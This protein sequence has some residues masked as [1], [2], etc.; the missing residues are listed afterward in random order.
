MSSSFVIS[1]DLHLTLLQT[2]IEV[3]RD[4]HGP[5]KTIFFTSADLSPHPN[6]TFVNFYLSESDLAR[7]IDIFT[8]AECDDLILSDVS[9][10]GTVAGGIQGRHPY[11]MMSEGMCIQRTRS[12]PCN[13]YAWALPYQSCYKD[14]AMYKRDYHLCQTDYFRRDPWQP[15]QD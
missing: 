11:L 1:G 14:V 2:A 13:A 3:L 6:F 15:G 4:R 10:F 8:L 12:D 7:I 9:T 5:D